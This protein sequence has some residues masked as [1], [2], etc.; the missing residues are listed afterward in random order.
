VSTT[1]VDLPYTHTHTRKMPYLQTQTHKQYQLRK[2]FRLLLFWLIITYPK[3]YL[4][5]CIYWIYESFFQFMYPKLS[6]SANSSWDY[7]VR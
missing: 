1:R 2:Y 7:F 6:D 5:K 3:P 4:Q